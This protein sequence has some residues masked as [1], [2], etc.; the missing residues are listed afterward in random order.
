VRKGNR[1]PV[2]DNGNG[3]DQKAR[4]APINNDC[5]TDKRPDPSSPNPGQ[6]NSAG[7]GAANQEGNNEPRDRALL[8]VEVDEMPK[9]SA[10]YPSLLPG[11][12]FTWPSTTKDSSPVTAT[13]GRLRALSPGVEMA[14]FPPVSQLDAHLLAS[15]S[16]LPSLNPQSNA[17][18]KG[19]RHDANNGDAAQNN[20]LT[21][22][23]EASVAGSQTFRVG[24]E[25]H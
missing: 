3:N 12:D 20:L 14:Q 1:A 24:R 23:R 6:E 5:D 13:S 4:M 9:F 8:D 15:Q 10:R 21:S 17:V 2:H 22:R 11:E 18:T 7:T 16:S 25:L 19:V